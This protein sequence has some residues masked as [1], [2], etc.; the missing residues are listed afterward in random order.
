MELTRT[1]AEAHAPGPA[2]VA[3]RVAEGAPFAL[4]A[5]LVAESAELSADLAAIGAGEV[6]GAPVQVSLTEGGAALLSLSGALEAPSALCGEVD[7]GRYPC[8]QGLAVEAGPSLLLF[9]RPPWVVQAVPEQG[10]ESLGGP[11]SLN[12]AGLFAAD[13]DDA[14]SYAAESSDPALASVAVSGGVLSIEPNGEGLEGFVTVTLTA[15]DSDG[16]EAVQSFTVEVSPQSRR[17]GSGWRLGWLL[18]APAPSAEAAPH[19][20]EPQ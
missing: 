18:G 12:L 8:F 15:T 4:S 20:A 16:L 17:F 7:E 10:V 6:S 2:T 19:P 9:K 11:L 14:L 1:D 5:G 13:G 3:A